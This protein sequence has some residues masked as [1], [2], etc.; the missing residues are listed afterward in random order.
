VATPWGAGTPDLLT[1]TSHS[2]P[3]T[4]YL[5]TRDVLVRFLNVMRTRL[6]LSSRVVLSQTLYSCELCDGMRCGAGGQ[7]A[8]RD[9]A[10]IVGCN[11]ARHTFTPRSSC[12]AL[13][14]DETQAA[15]GCRAGSTSGC[16]LLLYF[17]PPAHRAWRPLPPP[18]GPQAPPAAPT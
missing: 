8:D 11:E 4:S 12:G 18:V 3:N 10:F 17:P 16:S 13:C 5:R 7:W 15:L 2:F 1:P 9:E 6:P 14:G